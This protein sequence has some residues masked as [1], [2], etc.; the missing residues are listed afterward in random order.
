MTR[1]RLLRLLGRILRTRTYFDRELPG[2]VVRRL[3][4]RGRRVAGPLSGRERHRRYRLAKQ[5]AKEGTYV[6]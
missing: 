6:R 2:W 4:G 1:Q 3:S 5:L